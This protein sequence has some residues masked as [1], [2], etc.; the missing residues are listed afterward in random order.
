MTTSALGNGVHNLLTA[1]A[2][3]AGAGKAMAQPDGAT[4]QTPTILNKGQSG[5]TFA[6]IRATDI[7]KFQGTLAASSVSGASGANFQYNSRL[8]ALLGQPDDP[9]NLSNTMTDFLNSF[10]ADI[11]GNDKRDNI[12]SSASTFTSRV[13][14]YVAG[15]QDI[16]ADLENDIA[17]SV[18]SINDII[19]RIVD[20]NK[21]LG[22]NGKSISSV[23]D[24]R[25]DLIS[26][27]SAL[28]SVKCSFNNNGMATISTAGGRQLVT[29]SGYVQLSY[30]EDSNLLSHNDNSDVIGVRYYGLNGSDQEIT[31]I[32][33]SDVKHKF[34]GKF[35]GLLD[36]RDNVL[37]KALSAINN[38]VKQIAFQVNE[39]QNSGSGFPPASS[40]T[41]EHTMLLGDKMA[42]TGKANFAITDANGQPI[43]DNIGIGN[44]VK[45]VTVDF[46][47]LRT[48]NGAFG[49]F[50][51]QDVMDEI[52]R[53]AEGYSKASVGLGSVA[54]QA[55]KP[56]QWLIDQVRL[57]PTSDI[58]AAGTMSFQL[59]L[60]SGSQFDTQFLVTR[61]Q[62]FEQDGTDTHYGLAAQNTVTVSAGQNVKTGQDIIVNL[63]NDDNFNTVRL[64]MRVIGANGLVEEKFA[65]FIIGSAG[66]NLGGA[67]ILN[68]R[69]EAIM[70]ERVLAPLVPMRPALAVG[71]V[72]ADVTA[73]K[74]GAP[75]VN[76]SFVDANGLAVAN[77][78]TPG[79][80]QIS[81][82]AGNGLIIDSS[83]TKVRSTNATATEIP[84]NLSHAYG[85]NNF[86][87]SDA[88]NPA[89]DLA[90]NG[91]IAGNSGM[92]SLG[93][94]EE[95]QQV[96]YIM[97]GQV[98]PSAT[99]DFGGGAP[100]IGDTVTIGVTMFAFSAAP[101]LATDVLLVGGNAAASLQNLYD[102]V[103][104]NAD[105]TAAVTI[106]PPVAG[107]TQLNITAKTAGAVVEVDSN[108]G[109]GNVWKVPASVVGGGLGATTT[110]KLTGGY[111]GA[112]YDLSGGNAAVGAHF[113]LNGVQFDFVDGAPVGPRQV[114]R[115]GG[116]VAVDTITNL[117]AALQASTDP[118]IAGLFTFTIDH[119][120]QNQ[121][122]ISAKNEGSSGNS[123]TISES[124]GG[125]LKS[126]GDVAVLLPAANH[127]IGGVDIPT[128]TT[129]NTHALQIGIGQN[130]VF[131]D[132]SV[133]TLSF[134]LSSTVSHQTISGFFTSS[135]QAK[136]DH[137]FNK[138]QQ[139]DKV[140][141]GVL[142]KLH[143]EYDR[144]TK[145]SGDSRKAAEA[146]FVEYLQYSKLL[147]AYVQKVI[148]W[149]N[150]LLDTLAR[151]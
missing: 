110:R 145:L 130:N 25:D 34:G 119:A 48:R 79:Y 118:R 93:K 52:N 88:I 51:T 64:S 107:A 91:T 10:D 14:A 68:Q 78:N 63:K 44:A 3:M 17:T 6:L 9:T 89:T 80:L 128:Q 35:A 66:V 54:V 73:A 84:K 96:Q 133:K 115:N 40:F 26:E 94:A 55:G 16:K 53:V 18:T 126:P 36:V 1:N 143:I 100:M 81:A 140:D 7:F 69:S 137:M 138:S 29:S 101:V 139:Q 75:V 116:G 23:E 11:L 42:F 76:A 50:S 27:L 132:L 86:F 57:V 124:E 148:E 141:S 142:E 92:I 147:T 111:A 24:Q 32:Q 131:N 2:A 60:N 21:T 106:T 102:V 95:N 120:H 8:G 97:K 105:V 39:L 38:T 114:Q 65:D 59:E 135:F 146:Q 150:Y 129:V 122:I 15:L 90:V 103:K 85:L 136:M 28:L 47:K 83:K 117:K 125:K 99:L 13:N 151:G 41:S 82:V 56:A 22:G 43:I 58:S 112:I 134:D 121:L 123:L 12:V 87:T 5:H 30:T 33:V 108:V 46:D 149:R 45:P 62:V 4:L 127:L 31:Q 70:S 109:A 67:Q 104:A 98:L 49:Q 19:T 72:A 74:L 144:I 37:P 61:M 71:E 77:A 20:I 113:T